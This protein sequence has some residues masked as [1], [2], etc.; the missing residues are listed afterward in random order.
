ML[1]SGNMTKHIIQTVI[2]CLKVDARRTAP[3]AGSHCRAAQNAISALAATGSQG[4]CVHG[5]DRYRAVTPRTTSPAVA[6][7]MQHPHT[8]ASC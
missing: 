3:V 4:S 7:Q 5:T 8:A 2:Y 1:T 6:D